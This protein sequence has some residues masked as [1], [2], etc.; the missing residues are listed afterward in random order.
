LA[1]CTGEAAAPARGTQVGGSGAS[2]TQVGGSGASSTQ[3]GGSGTGG[4]GTTTGGAAA[5]P[6]GPWIPGNLSDPAAA[7][8]LPLRMLTRTQYDNTIALV[9]GDE[10]GIPIPNLKAAAV[11]PGETLD[12]SGFLSVG[13]ISEVHVLRYMDAAKAVTDALAP[14]L[15]KLLGCD[16]TTVADDSACVRAFVANFGELL[17][18]R[19]LETTEIDEHLAFYQYE[20]TSLGQAPAAA[21]TQLIRTM[22]QSPYFL[23]RWEQGW[24]VAERQGEVVRLNPYQV[25]ARLSF[26]LWGSGPD[27]QLIELAKSGAFTTDAQ[28]AAQT[29]AMLQSPRA[30]HALES[31]HEQWLALTELDAMVKDE[32]RFPNWNGELRT[33]MHQEIQAFTRDVILNNDGTVAALLGASY[34]F[35]NQGLAGVYGVPGIQGNALQ[36]AELDPTQRAG[37]LTMPGLLASA[38][39]PS[40]A[41]PFKRGKLI[42]QKV[43]CQKLEPPPMVPALPTP[44]PA[45]PKPEREV[46]EAMTAQVPCSVCHSVINPIGF[47]LSNFDAIG[48]FQT[49]DGAGFPIDA[50]GALPSGATFKTPSELAAA[51]S[52]HSDVRTCITKQWFRFGFGRAE[53]PADHF[54]LDA[55]YGSFDASGYN[56]R[57]LLVA[58]VTTPSFLRRV[59][60]P[61]EIVQ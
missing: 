38:S 24:K 10:Y 35:I 30:E 52:T 20:K 44:D 23:Y 4:S 2:S 31:F 49:K 21:A 14:S 50:S 7:A 36:R 8:V 51:L 9:F 42:L 15:P 25:A 46:L 28:L 5:V 11:L 32:Q 22:L 27:R 47:G 29:R 37:L 18:R 57:E 61:G 16:L 58:F 40:V 34:S 45:V 6:Q 41:N 55:A 39:D 26:F 17:Y 56:I 43:L 3:V 1:A 53:E 12:V 54:S 59:V 33:A 48:Q 13:E 19:P 60:E